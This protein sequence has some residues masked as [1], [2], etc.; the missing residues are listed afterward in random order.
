[1]NKLFFVL[2]FFGCQHLSAQTNAP[3]TQFDITSYVVR[4][5]LYDEHD[6]AHI[7]TLVR[8]RLVNPA[9]RE[10]VLDLE[11]INP[12]N[13]KGMQVTSVL[14]Q[15]N[16]GPISFKQT[17]TQV[18]IT[19]T[20]DTAE[21]HFYINYK[22][23]PADGLI[24]GQ[25]KFGD[26]TFFSDNWPDRAANWLACVNHPLDKASFIW[27]V[28]VPEHYTVTANGE[29]RSEIYESPGNRKTWVFDQQEPIP[30]K[31]AAVGVAR[32]NRFSLGQV[33]GIPVSMY[34]YP[35]LFPKHL[36]KYA[37]GP[38]ILLFFTQLIGPYPFKKLAHVQ[39]TTMFGGMEN[40]GNIFYDELRTDNDN[41][42]LEALVAH[43]T[44]HQWFGNSVTEKSYAHLWLSEGFAT[45]LTHYYLEKKYGKDT[46]KLRLKTDW[47]KVL[48]FEKT[49]PGPVINPTRKY[50]SLLNANSYQKGAL[51]LQT[52]R[53]K[54]GDT[55][56]FTILRSFYNKYKYRNADTDDFRAMVEQVTRKN[57][58]TFF[59]DWLYL[60]KLPAKYVP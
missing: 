37:D 27:M 15:I 18:I 31:V 51:F 42:N 38:D 35:K 33:N 17:R 55:V 23:I 50:L 36:S 58:K 57:W 16:K 29:L 34:Y 26:R 9:C 45:F 2:L 5:Q 11:G 24:I 19:A 28:D 39:S 7:S 21:Q 4:I 41:D 60:P 3:L 49:N 8:Y 13:G 30:V 56:F 48:A 43:E 32:L 10:I 14:K 54:T 12:E 25:N 22:G 44:A 1:M 53:E 59:T 20:A 46:L 52:L 47:D 6:S 40:A